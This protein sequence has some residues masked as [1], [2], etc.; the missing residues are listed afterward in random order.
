MLP[1][2]QRCRISNTMCGRPNMRPT[3]PTSVKMRIEF[4][5]LRERA[6]AG[7]WIDFAVFNA[8]SAS[9]ADAENASFLA[10]LTVAARHQGLKIDQAA[11]AYMQGGQLRFYGT[12]TLVDYLSKHGLP[13]WTHHIDI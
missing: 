6:A 5:H 4:A 8:R 10:Q 2:E 13:R 1:R 12:T 11:L 9:G 3:T 7:G